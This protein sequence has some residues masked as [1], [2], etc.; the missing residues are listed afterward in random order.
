MVAF[1][2]G[3]NHHEV[4][5]G[6]SDSNFMIVSTESVFVVEKNWTKQDKN[7]TTM[8]G[9]AGLTT[10]SWEYLLLRIPLSGASLS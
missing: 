3:L 4:Y 10:P 8:S 6:G 9:V 7:M 2:S 1:L 5:G